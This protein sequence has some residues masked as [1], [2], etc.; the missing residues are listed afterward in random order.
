MRHKSTTLTKPYLRSSIRTVQH[1]EGNR[2]RRRTGGKGG[3]F[4]KRQQ[5]DIG[6]EKRDLLDGGDFIQSD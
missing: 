2:G 4:R 6:R 5:M 3:G 1:Q